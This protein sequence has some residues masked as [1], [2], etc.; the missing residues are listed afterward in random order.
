M[1]VD[2]FN[3]MRLG[4]IAGLEKQTGNQRCAMDSIKVD[5]VTLP[6]DYKRVYA[7]KFAPDGSAVSLGVGVYMP[8]DIVH[9]DWLA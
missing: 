4:W 8:N 5:K 2:S 9:V 1:A 3:K 7:I 6:E